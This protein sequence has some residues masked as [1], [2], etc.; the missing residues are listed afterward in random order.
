M[1]A[2]AR[3]LE[4]LINSVSL[5]VSSPLQ[6]ARQTAEILSLALNCREPVQEWVS[7]LPDAGPA[8][9]VAQV[10]SEASGEGAVILV[11][12]EPQISMLAA[13]LLGSP[14]HAFEFKKGGACAFQFSGKPAPA[15]AQLE[16]FLTPK[17]LR[18]IA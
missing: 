6:R 15:T 1:Q 5:V 10:R 14:I 3:G 17:Q 16:W 11:G 7:L 4:R 12:H 8:D 18:Q 13:Y 9:T 2:V